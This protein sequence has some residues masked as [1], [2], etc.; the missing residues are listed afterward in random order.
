MSTHIS[1]LDSNFLIVFGGFSSGDRRLPEEMSRRESAKADRRDRILKAAHGLLRQLPME[2][3]TVK[4]IAVRAGLSAATVFN[5][6]GSKGAILAGVFDRDLRAFEARVAAAPS[7]DALERLF[8]SV[9]IAADFYRRDPAFYRQT[10]VARGGPPQ[11]GEFEIVVREPRLR[12]WRG[13]VQTA[14]AE[15]LLA[16]DADAGRISVLLGQIANGALIDWTQDAIDVDRLEAELAFG[17]AACLSAFATPP[18]AARLR[19]RLLSAR[20]L[21]LAGAR[22]A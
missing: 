5:L 6:F 4:A 15:G 11:R 18:A 3:V 22:A 14:I 2:A 16:A 9:T 1:G 12:Y 8:A 13:L 10:M 17:F 21:G 19:E 20:P 7:A